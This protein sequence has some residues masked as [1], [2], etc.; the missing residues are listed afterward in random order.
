M[1]QNISRDYE[2]KEEK[3]KIN[4]RE[5]FSRIF[6]LQNI[7]IYILTFMS[8]MVG[9]EANSSVLAPFGLAMV[10]A[11]ISNGIPV[12]MVYISSLI[13]TA[14]GFGGSNL[15]SYIF[16]SIVMLLLILIKKPASY[17]EENEKIRLGSYLFISIF[18]VQAIMM[19]F[20]GF[21]VYEYSQ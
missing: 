8:S 3:A 11:S 6:T 13:G 4:Y 21:Y 2:E 1:L 18:I 12:A 17:E 16:T 15:L 14:V 10:A 19:I 5:V 7:V 20:R 9:F